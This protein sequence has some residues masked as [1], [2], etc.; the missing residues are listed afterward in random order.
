MANN[1]YACATSAQQGLIIDEATGR[2][3]AVAYDETD[4]D[5]IAAAPAML[6]ALQMAQAT[7]ERHGIFSI[8]PNGKP[9]NKDETVRSTTATTRTFESVPLSVVRAAIRQAEGKE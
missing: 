2:N 5:L 6:A 3:V 7:L 8:G 9:A 1:W 4:K